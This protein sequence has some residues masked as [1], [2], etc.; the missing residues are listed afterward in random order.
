MNVDMDNILFWF[1]ELVLKFRPHFSG[2]G[3]RLIRGIILR[4]HCRSWGWPRNT[5]VGVF[6]FYAWTRN[7]MQMSKVNWLHR[8]CFIVQL[9][10]CRWRL[11]DVSRTAFHSRQR[12]LRPGLLCPLSNSLNT[13]PSRHMSRIDSC[14][15]DFGKLDV[16]GQLQALVDLPSVST[17]QDVQ[18]PPEPIR[19]TERVGKSSSYR[20]SNSDPLAFNP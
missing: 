20:A 7:H 16:N 3:P 17:G 5:S 4:S 13:T 14:I 9:R 2:S 18:W 10:L 11:E 1:V 15:L 8:C 12:T 19:T 6:L